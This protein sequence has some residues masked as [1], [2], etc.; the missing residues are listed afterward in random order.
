M[1][2]IAKSLITIVAVLA[3]AAGATGAVFSD[4]GSIPGNT[5]AT[6]TL[7]LTLHHSAGKPFSVSN[8]YPGYWTNWEH[9]DIFNGPFPPVA[10]QLPFEA[11]MTVSKTGG[12]T[13]LWDNL[14]VNMKT[15]GWNSDCTD[16]DGGERTIYN[17]NINAF[18]VHNLVSTALYWHLAN[19]DDGHASPADNI[20][21][22]YSERVCQKVGLLTSADN[23]VQGKSVTFTE[24][25]DAEQDN[26]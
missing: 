2:R 4:Q 23:T 10:G 1:F 5:F 20:R 15:S 11:Y 14:Q 7:E 9:M 8:A 26:D 19:E 18:P 21:A 12:S 16:G 3:I 22:G 17:G 6:G 24:I 13:V 25:V